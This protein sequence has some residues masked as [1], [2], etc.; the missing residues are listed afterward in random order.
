MKKVFCGLVLFFLTSC[1]SYNSKSGEAGIVIIGLFV[2]IGFVML[3]A[4]Y[5]SGLDSKKPHL[6]KDPKTGYYVETNYANDVFGQSL[7]KNN[8]ETSIEKKDPNRFEEK[9]AKIVKKEIDSQKYNEVTWLQAFKKARGNKQEAQALYAE[10]RID[11]LEEQ[12]YNN[13]NVDQKSNNITKVQYKKVRSG[14]DGGFFEN[15][16]FLSGREELATAF[17]LY[18]FAGNLVVGIIAGFLSV[19]IGNFMMIILIPYLI[20]S[21][22]GLWKCADNYTALKQKKK[23]PYGWALGAKIYVII[24]LLYL[25]VQIFQFIRN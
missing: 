15:S 4:S 2:I 3:L 1:S 22:V 23:E 11:Q 5:V 10:Y 20:F 9:I 8:E 21:T 18:V 13:T 6:I 24:N 17:W 19:G 12:F 7:K 14:S 16:N 25:P